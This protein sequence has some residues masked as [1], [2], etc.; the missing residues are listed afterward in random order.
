MQPRQITEKFTADDIRKWFDVADVDKNGSL[1]INEFFIW[2]LSA[3]SQKYGASTLLTGFEKHDRDGS[4]TLDLFEFEK[5]A[6]AIGFGAVAHTIFQD[7]DRDGSGLV[8]YREIT[9]AVRAEVPVD[10]ETKKLVTA[11]VWASDTSTK[12][13]RMVAVS[14]D[15][16]G[17]IIR[18]QDPE[19]VRNELRELLRKSGKQ[20]ADL[21]KL[22]D[23]DAD[24]ALLIDDMEFQ[25]AMRSKFGYTGTKAVLDRVFH[26]LDSDGSGKIG[27]DEYA[28]P[29]ELHPCCPPVQLS[30]PCCTGSS[31]SSGAAATVST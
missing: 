14:M 1:S 11:L 7:F 31:S 29:I 5:A 28:V 6:T 23:D 2:S 25:K 12:E 24:G 22:F 18:G 16:S 15:T 4:G 21:I 3:S 20:V 19:S 26:E 10:P 30:V 17:W 9:E 8:S 27:F 13:E